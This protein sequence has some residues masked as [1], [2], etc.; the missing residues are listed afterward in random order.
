MPFIS[1]YRGRAFAPDPPP[2]RQMQTSQ[3]ATGAQPAYSYPQQSFAPPQAQQ[4][5]GCPQPTN[6][7]G[8]T[9]TTMQTPSGPLAIS[10]PQ[11]LVASYHAQIFPSRALLEL[12]LRSIRHCPNCGP[13]EFN[14]CS[15]WC[16]F[17]RPAALELTQF[18]HTFS[19]S[20][21]RSY[22]FFNPKPDP[23]ISKPETQNT[24]HKT[25]TSKP[26]TQNPKSKT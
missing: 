15:W 25:Q 10:T 8:T 24:K 18:A 20:K 2:P 21:T 19:N 5:Y 13:P 6:A 16:A 3:P 12:E 11:Q 22:L 1:S 9:Y 26:K 14:L 17:P 23:Q 7:A 4:T